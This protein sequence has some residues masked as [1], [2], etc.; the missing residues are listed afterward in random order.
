MTPRI[1]IAVSD[2]AGLGPKIALKTAA[3][4]RVR[5]ARE[6]LI[7]SPERSTGVTMGR[8]FVGGALVCGKQVHENREI[9]TRREIDRERRAVVKEGQR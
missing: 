1:S 3:D 7:P 2:P 4:W 6:P 9:I 8:P 5:V